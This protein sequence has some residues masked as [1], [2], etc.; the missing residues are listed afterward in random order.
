MKS[1]L[2]KK[3]VTVSKYVLFGTVL[4]CLL[5]T[6]IIARDGMAQKS[7]ED[8]Y[9]D[10]D[11]ENLSV[12]DIFTRI[13]SNTDFYF[14]YRKSVIKKAVRISCSKDKKASVANILRDIS[15]RADLK[16]KRID[17]VIHVSKSENMGSTEGFQEEWLQTIP[18][19]GRVTSF[20]DGEGLPGVN[21]IIKGTTQ[22]TITDLE[23]RFNLDVPE[24]AVLIFSY[25]G[26]VSEEIPV[27]N[28]SV[29]DVS[30]VPDI[31]A[32]DEIIVVG[33][34]TQKK[35]DVTG[36]LTAISE[37]DIREVPSPNIM[38]ALQGM[39][40]GIDIQKS[41]GNNHPGSTPTIR[42]RGS[43][44]L[45]AKNDPL[46]VVDGIPFDGSIND[47][48]TNDVVS[49]QI[50][51]DAS[52]TAIYGSRGANGVVLIN[53]RRGK[54]QAPAFT[55]SA[56]VGFNKALATYD[57]MD[58]EEFFEFK[59]WARYFGSKDG[60][61]TGIDDP[62]LIDDTFTDN[63][64]K[65][66]YYAGNNTDWQD[67]IYQTGFM[68]N[69]QLGLTGGNEKTQYA[70]SLGYYSSEGNYEA[71]EFDR[72]TLKMRLDQNIGKHIKVGINSLNSYVLLNGLD[73][74]PMS[75]ALQATPFITPYKEDG[76][77]WH[78]LPGSGGN[79][80]NPLLDLE[81]GAIVDEKKRLSTFTTG[82]LEIDFTH[83]FK[84]KLNAGIQLNP[85]TQG[86]YYASATT[87]Q[88]DGE[89]YAFNGN[90]TG[91]NYT[92]ENILTYDKQFAED[93]HINFTG[94]YSIQEKQYQ[95]NYVHAYD[96]LNDNIQYHNPKFASA[97][98]NSDGSYEK[99]DLISYMA[100]LNYSFKDK[101]L[102]TAT[103][104]T[105]GSSR[106]A[107]GNK[108][109]TFPS[110]AAGWHI[111]RESFLE[112]SRLISDL[113]LRASYGTV[114]NTSLNAY[115]TMGELSPI[116]YVF[117]SENVIGAYPT[118]IP[119]PALTWENT[120]SINVGIDYGVLNNRLTGSLEY[121]HQYT[122]SL[123]LEQNLPATSGVTEPYWN[124][125][126][127]TENKGMEFNLSSINFTGNGKESFSW[128]T[129]F[130]IFFN[131]NEI[132]SL[133]S[134]VTED[135]GSGWFV[136]EPIGVI[137]DYK[138]LGIWQN[139]PEDIA[140]AESYG[141]NTTGTNSV[142]GTIKVANTHLD[143]EEDGTLKEQQQINDDDKVII[144]S[145]QPDFEGGITN[146]FAYKNFDFSFVAGYRVG[147]LIYSGMYGGWMN[148]FE[149]K[150]NNLDVDY[151][152]PDNPGNFWP[153]PNASKQNPDYKSTISYF[154]ASYLKIRSITLGYSLPDAS[155][156][157]FGIRSA[158]FYATALNPF[159]FFSEYVDEYGGVD[160][161]SAGNL[162]LY[163]PATWS[164]LVGFNIQ[165]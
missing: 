72:Y 65:E 18:V 57:V 98:I 81:P 120:S 160:P 73:A 154:D 74:N 112:N 137:Y 21:V 144:G 164:M 107:D 126:G 51:K 90:G 110:V 6:V 156:E 19:S 161:E 31:T 80:Y 113:K 84:Y 132:T 148:T 165:F 152:T 60:S 69:H 134:G 101:Y 141:L 25:I 102:L 106:L 23:G 83:G 77:L 127:K 48:N 14:A 66:G 53:T 131:R 96:L 7:L 117:G 47:I 99:W 62:K 22:G 95:W 109:H 118:D 142:I 36:A 64:E 2:L 135:I 5:F 114:G 91:Y 92:I 56:Y 82:Y 140:L 71:H 39:G 163:T 89:S 45:S 43:R 105:D 79:V 122:S 58:S 52:S 24:D 9:V 155:I 88:K 16:F 41:N 103:V 54:D 50:L 153:K 85:E 115:A 119:N 123:L 129:D 146:R 42:I 11:A 104:R 34:G 124:N 75:Q 133:A 93:H 136:G 78:A 162:D 145:K 111:G 151:W 12:E 8:V 28:Q 40:T 10:L 68:T 35:S 63:D 70:V 38:S 94:L 55:Y 67:Q 149:G 46:I 97:S 15:E 32:L 86:R 130:N 17:N 29:I 139:T 108:W 3:I 143:Y 44:S 61:Y 27:S 76:S 59:K 20:Q 147:G 87:R 49:V 121:Y 157:R 128:T 30:M 33:Y 159:V 100:R 37:E 116:Y 125:I 13:E 158:R 150:Y 4:Q 1:K 138:R 26:F